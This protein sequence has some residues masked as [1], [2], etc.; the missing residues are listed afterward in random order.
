MQIRP[1]GIKAVVPVKNLANAKQRLSAI[2]SPTERRGFYRAM[3]EDV[4]R[5]LGAVEALDG[6]VLVTKDEEVKALASAHGVEVL[7]ENANNG[8]SEAVS[9]GARE[10]AARDVPGLLTLPGDVPLVT[11]V[12]IESV[13]NAHRGAPAVT[14]VPSGDELGSNAI[15][16]SPPDLL[17]FGFGD[18]SFYPHLERA[19]QLG[20]E[21]TVV[22]ATGLGL[23]I[24][25]PTDLTR[26][27]AQASDTAAFAFLRSANILE[28]LAPERAKA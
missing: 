6:I 19:R 13:L 7:E 17:P 18:N 14:I 10:L 11:A 12:E 25:T 1:A 15:V 22:R 20:V 4:L 28:R 3:L 8:H 2:L 27:A 24:D 21:P 23:D 26:F 5:A 16:C 9:F